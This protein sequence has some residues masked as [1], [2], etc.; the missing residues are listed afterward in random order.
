MLFA[1]FSVLSKLVET[2]LMRQLSLTSLIIS[3]FILFSCQKGP[4]VTEQNI[5]KH[6]LETED[7]LVIKKEQAVGIYDATALS[8]SIHFVN[9]PTDKNYQWQV[10]PANGCVTVWGKYKNGLASIT[11]HCAGKYQI[12][13]NIY[14]SA[15]QRMISTTDTVLV[16]V[17]NETLYPSQPIKTDDVLNL[18]PGIVQVWDDP[19]NWN[20]DTPDEVYIQI[21]YS[22]THEYEYN[23]AYNYIGL[24]NLVSAGNYSFNFSD[25]VKLSSYPFSNGNGSFGTVQG[26]IDLKGLS[27]GVPANLTIGW[28]GKTYTGK[29]TLVSNKL[30]S[31]QW[32]NSGNVKIN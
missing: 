21:I 5:S 18:R 15:T 17:G 11:F 16:E 12:F 1:A 23:S 2:L 30:Y 25:S 14:D 31:F 7:D 29:V 13:A 3:L 9:P 8:D 32:D 24:T 19:H 28:L 4:D 26:A 20:T 22:T 27:I 10:I 6:H